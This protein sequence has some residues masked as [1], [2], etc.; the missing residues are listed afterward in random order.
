MTRSLP[1]LTLIATLATAAMAA[2]Q[3][4]GTFRWQLQPFCNVVTLAVTQTGSTFRVEG[5][6]DQCGAASGAASAIGTA[7]L[8]PDGH[9]GFGINI[10]AAPGGGPV[11]VEATMSTTS[12]SGTW[13]DSAGRTGAFVFTPG[14]GSGGSPRPPASALTG[15]AVGSGLVLGGTPGQEFLTLNGSVVRDIIGVRS[16]TFGSLGLGSGAL[17][18]TVIPGYDNTAF[19][20]G[21]LRNTTTGDNNTAVGNAVMESNTSGAGNTAMGSFAMRLNSGGSDNTAFGSSGPKP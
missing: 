9:V 2:A 15:V 20:D 18:N 21:A 10:V 16:P 1:A 3:P 17:A 13:R 4:L 11:H 5:T 8:N 14:A 19:G 7:F 6:D 12:F